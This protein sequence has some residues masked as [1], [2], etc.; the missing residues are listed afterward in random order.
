MDIVEALR[1]LQSEVKQLSERFNQPRSSALTIR[2]AAAEL[3]ISESKLK[4]LIRKGE[5]EFV[6][7]GERRRIPRSEIDRLCRPARPSEVEAKPAKRTRGGRRPSGMSEAAK[8]AELL[9]SKR[10]RR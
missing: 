5:V 3:E 1:A 8:F 2:H 7:I 10:R 6:L 9:K 4:Q